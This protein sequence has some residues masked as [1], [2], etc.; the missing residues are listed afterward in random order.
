VI[1]LLT[2]LGF[3]FYYTV[4][5]LRTPLDPVDPALPDISSDV[6]VALLSANSIYLATKF[7]QTPGRSP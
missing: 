2:S 4:T 6:L 7:A 1:L 5:A 3:A